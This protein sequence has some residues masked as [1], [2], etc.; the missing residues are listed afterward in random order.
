MIKTT[1]NEYQ[2]YDIVKGFSS[3]YKNQFSYEGFHALFNHL[4]Q[5]SEEVEED[6]EFD[7]ISW[8]CDFTE[9]ANIKELQK[10]YPNIIEIENSDRFIIQNF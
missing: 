3:D 7:F 2:A 5:Y 10:T 4:E 1:L 6:L 8:C 9:Y